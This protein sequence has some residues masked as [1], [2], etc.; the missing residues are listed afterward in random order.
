MDWETSFVFMI[1]VIGG[2]V[3]LHSHEPPIYHRDIKS[4]N[5]LVNKDFR[6]KVCDFGL[7]RFNTSNNM[8]T[9]SKVC[10]TVSY[11]APEVY[12]GELFTSK[13]DIFRFKFKFNYFF[14][15]IF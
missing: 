14:S 15:Y 8:A 2:I 1:D 9:M 11:L 13:A 6:S 4:L 7:S 5:Y 10:G 3:A 12:S